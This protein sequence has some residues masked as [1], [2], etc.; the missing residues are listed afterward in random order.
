MNQALPSDDE[1]IQFIN[2]LQDHDPIV[3]EIAQVIRTS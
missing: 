1:L 3:K 2:D